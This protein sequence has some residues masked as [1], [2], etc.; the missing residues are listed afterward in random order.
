MDV[1]RHEVGH[2]LMAGYLQFKRGGVR[3][4]I[5]SNSM[6]FGHEGSAKIY[7]MHDLTSLASI[8]T[9]VKNRISILYAG[10]AAQMIFGDNG[11]S[12]RSEKLLDEYGADDNSKIEELINIVRG[13]VEA[14]SMSMENEI[15]HKNE[16]RRQCWVTT[17]EY[18]QE[19]ELILAHISSCIASRVTQANEQYKFEHDQLCQ[20]FDEASKQNVACAKP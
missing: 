18:L 3:I 5:L 14:G 20:W 10:V 12:A 16:I 8:V 9:Y 11:S 17:A 19:S 1:I 4:K 7:P 6:G 15:D 2:W 13:I